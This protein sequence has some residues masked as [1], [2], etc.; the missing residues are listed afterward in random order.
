MQRLMIKSLI[1]I[2]PVIILLLCSASALAIG[3]S[4]APGEMEF[5]VRPGDTAMKTLYVI[6][7][8]NQ[9]SE[10]QVY[11][12]GEN[13][14]WFMITPGEF[15]LNPLETESVEITIAP[16][17]MTEPEEHDLSIC[18]VSI[19]PA[20]DL[21]IG[22][23]IK[24]PVHIQVI[25]LPLMAIQWWIASIAILVIVATSLLVLWWRKARHA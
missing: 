16:P 15:A 9:E 20:S 3:I 14:D 10:F 24:V 17:L 25:E 11:V 18:I 19:P 12:E 8:A 5:C 1:V 2:L 13:K 7:Q 23:G 21:S 22:A 6:N 4:I